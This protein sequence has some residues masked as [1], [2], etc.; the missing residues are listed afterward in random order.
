MMSDPFNQKISQYLDGDLNRRE[1]LYLLTTLEQQPH[2][3]ATMQRYQ[4][5]NQALKARPVITANTDFVAQ[6]KQKLKEEPVY[7]LPRQPR[8][9]YYKTAALALA[10]SLTAIAVIVPISMKINATYSASPVTLAQRSTPPTHTPAN[11]ALAVN[12]TRQPLRIVP[13]NKRFQDYLQAHNGSLY[14][15]GATNFQYRP[16]LASYGG[17][18]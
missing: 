3:Q 1:S 18:E 8:K 7:L 11:E 9:R 10:A 6:L 12:H 4:L 15:N 5:I 17:G 2:L 13:V 14:T 16:Q